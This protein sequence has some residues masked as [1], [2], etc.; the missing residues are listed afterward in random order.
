[1]ALQYAGIPFTKIWDA[2]VMN[3]SL[4]DYDWLHLHHE[5]FTGQYSK[6]FLIYSGMAWLAEMVERN[7]DMARRLG[8]GTVPD[9]KKAVAR[10]IRGYVDNGGFLFAMCTPPEPIALALPAHTLHIPPP[11]AA[12]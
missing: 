1:M 4:R 6:F 9:L 7:S 5:D 10:S 3:G 11:L 12:P 8:F 2:E